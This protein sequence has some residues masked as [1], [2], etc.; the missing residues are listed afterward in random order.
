MTAF[1]G[2]ADIVDKTGPRV[3]RREFLNLTWLA[4]LGFIFVDLGAVT[5]IFAMPRFRASEF[6]GLFLL[7]S[8]EDLP[9]VGSRPINMPS[10][11][12]W[13]VRSPEGL[14]ALYKVCTHLGCLY[15]WET[16]LD[17]FRCP[18]HGSKFL[19][20]GTRFRA[21]APRSLDRLVIQA[22]DPETG[23]ILAETSAEGGPLPIPEDPKTI[24]MVDTGRRI[25]GTRP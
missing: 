23:A 9:P 24:L 25:Q 15:D 2:D 4:S 16:A 5:F 8:V 22:L 12:F 21:P 3:S 20:D 1:P 11:R 18:C 10:G 14:L 7:G 17:R 19:Y 6:G 13:L